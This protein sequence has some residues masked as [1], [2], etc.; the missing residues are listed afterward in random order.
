MIKHLKT[1]AMMMAPALA[2][3]ALLVVLRLAQ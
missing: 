2:I 3:L 1:G